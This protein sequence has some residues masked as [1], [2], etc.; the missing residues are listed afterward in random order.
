MRDLLIGMALTLLSTGAMAMGADRTAPP[1]L[2]YADTVRA[3]AIGEAA[4]RDRAIDAADLVFRSEGVAA[5]NSVTRGA[6][7][8]SGPIRIVCGQFKWKNGSGGDERFRWYEATIK[9][10]QILW[11][12]E[13]VVVGGNVIAVDG[14]GAAYRTCKSIGLAG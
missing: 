14:P 7:Q 13:D 6:E 8:I 12:D 11:V 4:V 2:N 1:A 5:A 3:I 10:G 9:D